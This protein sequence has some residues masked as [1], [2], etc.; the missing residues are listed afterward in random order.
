M[1]T[2]HAP[3]STVCYRDLEVFYTADL[4]GGG[5]TFGREFLQVVPEKIG[6]VDH[7]CEFCAGP[8]FIA[9]SLLAHDLCRRLT[10]TDINPAAL[11]LCRRTAEH[12]ALTDR[13]TCIHS[14][15]LACVPATEKWDLVVSNPPHWTEYDGV[16]GTDIRRFDINLEIHQRFYARIRHHLTPDGIILFQENARA[17]KAEDFTEMIETNGLEIVDTFKATPDSSFYFMQIRLAR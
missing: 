16:H 6:H 15:A 13:V 8:A 9:Y 3:I 10:L 12:N 4:E 14:D 1:Q 17:T 11:E 2:D 5:R 7:L